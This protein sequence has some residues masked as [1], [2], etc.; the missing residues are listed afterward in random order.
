MRDKPGVKMLKNVDTEIGQRWLILDPALL[1][2][3]KQDSV[4][5]EM[6]GD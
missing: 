1:F 2:S 6:L 3:M 4:R 5:I